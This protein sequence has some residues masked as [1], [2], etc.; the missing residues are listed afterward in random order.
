MEETMVGGTT[1]ARIRM[2]LARASCPALL[3]TNPI[4]GFR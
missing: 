1:R 3:N 2:K 4:Y